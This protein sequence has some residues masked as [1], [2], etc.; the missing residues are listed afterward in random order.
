M[1]LVPVPPIMDDVPTEVCQ[2][3]ADDAEPRSRWVLP[4]TT[5]YRGRHVTM[6]VVT[7]TGGPHLYE[8]Y[9]FYLTTI[10]FRF[11]VCVWGGEE[12]VAH[13]VLSYLPFGGE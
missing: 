12:G 10:I 1:V 7:S 11:S 2:V 4:W 5:S 13:L 3:S 9:L 6:S 8:I